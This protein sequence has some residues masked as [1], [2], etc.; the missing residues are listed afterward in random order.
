M[1]EFIKGM[2]LCEGFFNEHIKPIIEEHFPNLK[3][4]A[5]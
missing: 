5:G 2:D 4:S 3:Y 1:P